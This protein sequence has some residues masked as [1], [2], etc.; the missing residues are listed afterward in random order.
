VLFWKVFPNP[1]PMV[2]RQ[3]NHSAFIADRLQSSILR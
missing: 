2:V 3:P 1:L